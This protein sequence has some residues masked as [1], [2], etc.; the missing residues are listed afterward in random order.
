MANLFYAHADQRP[1]FCDAEINALRQIARHMADMGRNLAQ[2]ARI[3]RTSPTC[4]QIVTTIDFNRLEMLIESESNAVK[5]LVRS[6]LGGWGVS[7]E[8]T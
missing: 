7:D 3:L 8:N 5:S 1:V 6:N 2:V 4:P